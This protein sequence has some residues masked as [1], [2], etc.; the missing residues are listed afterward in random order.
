VSTYYGEQTAHELM[1]CTTW[2]A[3][4]HVRQVYWFLDRL[5]IGVD[6]GLAEGDLQGLPIPK[7]VWS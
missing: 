7:A 6:E 2:H 3:A 4:Q 5:G 1:E